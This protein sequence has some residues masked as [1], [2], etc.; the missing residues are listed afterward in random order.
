MGE[1]GA[2]KQRAGSRER[3]D[4]TTVKSKPHYTHPERSIYII[5]LT[6]IHADLQ[7]T[8]CLISATLGR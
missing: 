5:L 1:E 2:L 4:I 7:Q 6:D 3:G 8:R